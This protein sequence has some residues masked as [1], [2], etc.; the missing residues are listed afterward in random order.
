M[1]RIKGADAGFLYAESPTMPF[2]T[3]SHIE[4]AAPAEGESPLTLP[5][6]RA[7][8]AEQLTLGWR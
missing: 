8:V 7:H 2:T 5:Q 6:L 1:R 4:L 3:T